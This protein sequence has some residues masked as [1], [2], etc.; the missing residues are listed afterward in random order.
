M[1]LDSGSSFDITVAQ[2][3]RSMTTL[4]ECYI[5]G[6]VADA[7]PTIAQL[8]IPLALILSELWAISLFYQRLV[9]QCNVLMSGFKHCE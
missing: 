2:A 9:Q 3:S 7:M 4:T 8:V 5:F 1:F 6:L